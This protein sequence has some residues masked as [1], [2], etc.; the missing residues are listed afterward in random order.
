MD[1]TNNTPKQNNNTTTDIKV[2]QG[3]E[4][5]KKLFRLT[6]KKILFSFLVL[7]FALV[8]FTTVTVYKIY[9]NNRIA[10]TIFG[11]TK[12]SAKN[13]ATIAKELKDSGADEK[14]ANIFIENKEKLK[15]LTDNI[16][17]LKPS[18]EE[19]QEARKIFYPNKTKLSSVEEDDVY[20]NL[21][22]Y[23]YKSLKYGTWLGSVY[24]FPFDNNKDTDISSEDNAKAKAIATLGSLEQ[25]KITSAEAVE[26]IVY[27]SAFDPANDLPNPSGDFVSTDLSEKTFAFEDIN[28]GIFNHKDTGYS[29]IEKAIKPGTGVQATGAYYFYYIEPTG[30]TKATSNI[31]AQVSVVVDLLKGIKAQY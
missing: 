25:N 5:V 1:Q 23:K 13:V 6:R 2:E 26:A 7:F 8:S 19:L 18:D 29:N 4:T 11:T 17:A 14:L 22:F 9:R 3:Q 12:Y 20:R 31:D 28:D 27:D 15:Y 16:P 24:V 10:L 21:V 30:Y